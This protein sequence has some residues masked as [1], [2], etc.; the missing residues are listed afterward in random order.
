MVL[1]VIRLTPGDGAED[2]EPG[3]YELTYKSERGHPLLVAIG[4]HGRRLRAEVE[5]LPHENRVEVGF[6]LWRLVDAHME[7]P[8]ARQLRPVRPVRAN[9]PKERDARRE[10]LDSLTPAAYQIALSLERQAQ[11]RPGASFHR[12]AVR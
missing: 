12:M 11:R 7:S 3:V 5:V 6:I 1:R 9:V 4:R 10:Y 8:L 2:V